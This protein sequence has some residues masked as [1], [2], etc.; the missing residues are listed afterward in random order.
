MRDIYQ[1]LRDFITTLEQRGELRRIKAPVNPR[2]EITEI[3]DRVMKE[4]GPALLFENVEGSQVPLAINLMGSRKRMSWALGVEDMEEVARRVEELTNLPKKGKGGLLAK[5]ALLPQLAELGAFGP[6]T[7]RSGPVQ[8]VVWTGE[9]ID[10][11]R[12]PVLTCWPDDGGPFITLPLVITRDPATGDRNVGMYRVQVLD[13]RTTAMHWQRHKTGARHFERARELGQR[14]EVAVALGGD[15]ALTYSASAPLPEGIDEFLFTG[16]LRRQGVELCKG[17]TVDLEVPAQADIVLEGYVDPSEPLRL[18]GPFGDHTGFY[19]LAD[20][21]PAFHVTCVTM[22]HDAVYPTTIVGKPPMEDYWMGHATE[23]IFLPLA[24]LMLPEIVDYHMPAEGV[25]HNLVFVSIEKKYPGHA[26]K[27]ANGLWGMGLMSLAKVLVI[28]DADVNIQDPVEAWWVTL[29]NIDPQRDT[30]FTSGPVDVL[31]HSSQHFS[32]G[33]KMVID[34]TRKWPEEGF[35]REWPGRITMT[36]EV[37]DLVSRRWRE[38]GL[39]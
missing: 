16:F 25:F 13:K 19:S 36:R 24:R 7:V 27:V 12:I 33:S 5:L 1:N 14:L 3:A 20:Y 23:R 26:Y 2:L 35:V 15:P 29:N 8:E 31:D 10:L 21:Y 39:G 6:R 9:E 17:R 11:S 22:R 28:L 4:G 30:R 38:Y 34:A 32:F 37:R 18:E